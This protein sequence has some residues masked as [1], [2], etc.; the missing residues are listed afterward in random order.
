[1]STPEILDNFFSALVGEIRARKPDYLREPFTVAEIYQN[2]V[3]YRT[4]RDRI[5][6]EMNADYEDALLRLL[7][8]EGDLLVLESDTARGEIETELRWIA[9]SE[10]ATGTSLEIDSDNSFAWSQIEDDE[11][12]ALVAV[13]PRDL[14]AVPVPGIPHRGDGELPG[15]ADPP[16]ELHPVGIQGEERGEVEGD[17]DVIHC[18][19]VEIGV[20]L[21]LG[22]LACAKPGS[23]EV[24]PGSQYFT[25]RD[26]NPGTGM[27]ACQLCT[28]LLPGAVI[29]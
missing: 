9:A 25:A 15:L 21:C 14:L 11:N 13:T 1:V 5:G 20:R 19:A 18:G 22:Q 26:Q 29:P 6:V 24:R 4:H 27:L 16:A 2:L 8:G 23:I 12:L 7:A 10:E 28:M 3:P 17:F